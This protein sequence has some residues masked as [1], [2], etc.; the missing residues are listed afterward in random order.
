MLGFFK[1]RERL[2]VAF[3]PPAARV[4]VPHSDIEIDELFSGYLRA[5]ESAWRAFPDALPLLRSLRAS[6]HRIGLL[7]NGTEAQQLA[8]LRRTGLFDAFDVVCTSERIGF[9]KPEARAFAVF[10]S[11]LG[12]EPAACLFVGDDPMKDADGARAAGM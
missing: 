12:V 4:D 7:T 8:K 10:T 2:A 11:E 5:Y 6:G 1:P 3:G 9:A